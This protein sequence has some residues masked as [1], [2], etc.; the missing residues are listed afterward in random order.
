MRELNVFAGSG[1]NRR[2]VGGIQAAEGMQT[3]Q[4]TI[5]RVTSNGTVFIGAKQFRNTSKLAVRHSQA[6]A[7]GYPN[8]EGSYR[9][10]IVTIKRAGQ[11]IEA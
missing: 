10:S 2:Y 6:V 4:G 3:N 9:A 1:K 5:T 8:S 11:V 7:F